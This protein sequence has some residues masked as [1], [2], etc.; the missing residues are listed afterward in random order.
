VTPGD[1]RVPRRL[2]PVQDL[3]DE[4]SEPAPAEATEPAPAEVTES[5]ADEVPL[6]DPL[7]E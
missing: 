2:L 1:R 5:D 6:A 4:V 7:E 3:P